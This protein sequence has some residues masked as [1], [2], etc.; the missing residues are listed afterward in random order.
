MSEGRIVTQEELTS[1]RTIECDVCV[2]GSGSGGSWT[3]LE[4]VRQGKSV[5]LLVAPHT[6]SPPLESKRRPRPLSSAEPPR[7]VL[8]ISEEQSG[9]RPTT[10][11]SCAPANAA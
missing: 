9:T 2:I 11:A 4:L 10:T 7:K 3:A 6:N 5:V 1:D 8:M